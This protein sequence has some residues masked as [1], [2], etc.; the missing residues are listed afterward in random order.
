M[1]KLQ[2]HLPLGAEIVVAAISSTR[3]HNP[4]LLANVDTGKGTSNSS[5]DGCQK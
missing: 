1:N 2:R 3:N 5:Q 4:V